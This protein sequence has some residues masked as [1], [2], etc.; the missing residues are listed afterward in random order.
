MHLFSF[1][2]KAAYSSVPRLVLA[3]AVPTLKDQQRPLPPKLNEV[4]WGTLL[5]L[6]LHGCTQPSRSLRPSLSNV[7][8]VIT[9]RFSMGD[10][11]RNISR[12]DQAV[13]WPDFTAPYST[14]PSAELSSRFR[15]TLSCC[16][17]T[18]T[19][20]EVQRYARSLYTECT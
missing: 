10:S 6:K 13:C 7:S 8:K 12:V 4:H 3:V 9:L 16:S 20:D 14:K 1:Q 15:L 5:V 18:S 11:I 2:K 19:V 17:T